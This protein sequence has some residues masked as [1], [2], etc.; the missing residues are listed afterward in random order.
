VHIMTMREAAPR[1]ATLV[2]RYQGREVTVEV[3]EGL[4]WWEVPPLWTPLRKLGVKLTRERPDHLL[5]EWVTM[6]LNESPR[7][8]SGFMPAPGYGPWDRSEVS[9]DDVPKAHRVT[10]KFKRTRNRC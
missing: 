1:K 3:T 7:E 8:T 5:E 4:R 9:A 6:A 10:W 2:L